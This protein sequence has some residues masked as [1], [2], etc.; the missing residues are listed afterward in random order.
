MDCVIS[1]I[2]GVGIGER[3]D[4]PLPASRFKLNVI[5]VGTSVE[6]NAG[7][8]CRAMLNYGFDQLAFVQP[9][10]DIY[11]DETRNRAKHAQRVLNEASV[12]DTL[13]EA[14]RDCSLV[15]GTS[16]KR[17][18]GDKTVK[19]HFLYPW[20][21]EQRISSFDGTIG[22]VFGEEGKGLSSEDLAKCDDL[23]T[24]PTWEGYPI[25][26][27]SHAVSTILY[28]LHRGRVLT[29]VGADPGL[30]E[31][32]PLERV[33]TPN[34]RHILNQGIDDLGEA[35]PGL[36][37]RGDSFSSVLKRSILRSQPTEDEATRLIGGLVDATTAL[38]KVNNDERWLKQRR[39]RIND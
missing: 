24:L 31:I 15:F 8:I 19:R 36:D 1:R 20:E 10:C 13:D 33:I 23:V 25:A 14:I 2:G 7:A 9:Q 32:V 18:T 11:S 30:P 3:K 21:F 17:E 26:N 39:R 37:E 5:L 28:E 4:I 29:N 6:G 12:Y 34:L 35:L 27:L 16:G 38:Q 22:L